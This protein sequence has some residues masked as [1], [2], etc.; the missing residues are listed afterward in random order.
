MSRESE[1]N[2][3]RGIGLRTGK[4]AT[5]AGWMSVTL[6]TLPTYAPAWGASTRSWG[7]EP[8][9]RLVKRRHGDVHEAQLADGPVAA[10]GPDVNGRHRLHRHHFA[11]QLHLAL[12][13]EDEVNLRHPLVVVRA[14]IALDVDD[15]QAGDVAGGLREGPAREAARAADGWRLIELRDEIIRHREGV[16]VQ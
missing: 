13:F 6:I 16:R 3:A 11:V 4:R 7:I 1:S 8:F 15:V 12:A 9:V 14:R 2:C 10:A 5:P